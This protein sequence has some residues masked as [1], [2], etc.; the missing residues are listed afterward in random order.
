MLKSWRYPLRIEITVPK[1]PHCMDSLFSQ[2]GAFIGS[3][4]SDEGHPDSLRF[5]PPVEC[6]DVDIDLLAAREGL[7]GKHIVMIGDSVVRYTFRHLV[8]ALHFG[9]WPYRFRGN[10]SYPSPVWEKDHANWPNFFYAMAVD[11]GFDSIRCDCHR[12]ET[13]FELWYETVYYRNRGLNLNVTF[14]LSTNKFHGAHYPLGY[15]PEASRDPS[16][17]YANRGSTLAFSTSDSEVLVDAILQHVGQVD[18]VV[19]ATGGLWRMPPLLDESPPAVRDNFYAQFERLLQSRRSP[20]FQTMTP[21]GDTGIEF[22]NGLDIVLRRG[23]RILDRGGV[24][25][26]LKVCGTVHN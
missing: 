10:S 1:V 3:L 24:L 5:V 19:I 4:A 22:P 9:R 15:Y 14:F 6:G 21:P 13:G 20:I 26:S 16:D 11:I 12:Q 23:W 25:R 17:L 18:E 8:Y 7:S 2:N